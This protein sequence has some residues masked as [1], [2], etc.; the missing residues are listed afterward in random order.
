[1][2]KIKFPD[3]TEVAIQQH[4]THIFP[5]WAPG[6]VEGP[7]RPKDDP[8]RDLVIVGVACLPYQAPRL[9]HGAQHDI[10]LSYQFGEGGKSIVFERDLRVLIE[11][12]VRYEKMAGLHKI[13]VLAATI[14]E[15]LAGWVRIAKRVADPTC[16]LAD[17]RANADGLDIN[18]LQAVTEDL[19][20]AV[21]AWSSYVDAVVGTM[22]GLPIWKTA[23]GKLTLEHRRNG[24]PCPMIVSLT[25]FG[26]DICGVE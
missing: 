7:I 23:G 24:E 19:G 15:A 21:D 25:L 16:R 1:V 26:I 11:A 3:G 18:D 22:R 6:V 9:E 13:G 14:D 17:L 2:A 20:R 8:D 10:I 4:T 12:G 5:A